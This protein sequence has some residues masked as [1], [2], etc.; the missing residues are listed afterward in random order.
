MAF[1]ALSAGKRAVLVGGGV[2]C[3]R[4]E[5]GQGVY[6][7]PREAGEEG[8]ER[9]AASEGERGATAARD[10]EEG[11]AVGEER[12]ETSADRGSRPHER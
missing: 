7:E 3:A 5:G 11:G 10:V 12:D 9:G 6:G 1:T 8:S 4:P 2:R